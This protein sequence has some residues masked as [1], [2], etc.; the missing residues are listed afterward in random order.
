M[1]QPVSKLL[2]AT[3]EGGCAAKASEMSK[4]DCRLKL[5]WRWQHVK[6]VSGRDSSYMQAAMLAVLRGVL[7][8]SLTI[9]YPSSN[10]ATSPS[11]YWTYR[12][13]NSSPSPSYEIAP[14]EAN[15]SP[16]PRPST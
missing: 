6:R 14:R 2:K 16:R 12:Q 7:W 10:T 4:P 9:A 15:V 5:L 8:R 11:Y 1:V 13:G 3:I